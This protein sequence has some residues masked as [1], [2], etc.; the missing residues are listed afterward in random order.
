MSINSLSKKSAAVLLPG[1]ALIVLSAV[2]FLA[3]MIIG[4]F[5]Q[6][7]QI[8]LFKGRSSLLLA[9]A[10]AILGMLAFAL[11]IAM[12]RTAG[13][14]P[15]SMIPQ[16]GPGLSDKDDHP[17]AGLLAG[18]AGELRTSVGAIREELENM[19]DDDIPVDN[20]HVQSLYDETD[21]IKKIL[22]GM[23]ELAKAGAAK[24]SLNRRPIQ[25]KSYLSGIIEQVRGPAPDKDILFSL[26]CE[27][28]LVLTAD[29]D[30]L[31]RILVNLLDNSVKAEKKTGAVT[32]AASRENGSIM[33][34]VRDS[35]AGIRPRDLP[36][37]FEPFYRGSGSGLGL[38]LP[39]AKELVNAHGGSIE[40]QSAPGKGSVFTVHFPEA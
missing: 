17:G 19:V 39:I 23:E 4:D 27:P 34:T 5:G 26:E 14:A 25:L 35:G 28:N 15:G 24:R 33:L 30:H 6:Q 1:T 37:I 31:N 32:V 13:K 7:E 29:L 8:A 2:L 21:R 10:F 18:T 40:V 11:V 9:A 38:G 36:H 20:E 22:D 12:S 16:A 3:A